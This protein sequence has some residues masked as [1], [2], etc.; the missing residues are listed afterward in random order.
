MINFQTKS[1]NIIFSGGQCYS[2]DRSF[3]AAILVVMMA[4]NYKMRN[5]VPG[6]KTFPSPYFK[7]LNFSKLFA[8]KVNSKT[9]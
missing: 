1:L 6:D 2:C 7:N 4:G 9:L 3:Q 8:I 5:A